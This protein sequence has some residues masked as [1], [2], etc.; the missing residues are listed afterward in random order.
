MRA[1]ATAVRTVGQTLPQDLLERLIAADPAL[2][3][4]EPTAYHLPPGESPRNAANRAWAYLKG[5]W[6]DFVAEARARPERDAQTGFTRDRWLHL[7]LRELGFG[8]V[9]TTPAGGISTAD[10]TYAVSHLWGQV[11]IHLLGWNV[12]LDRR[13][14]GVTGAAGRAPHAMVQELLNRADDYL[15]AIVS[16]GRLLRLLRD[17]TSLTGVSYV[18]FDLEAIFDQELYSDFVLLY[19]MVHQSRVETL[20][21]GAAS[22]CWL[23]RWRTSA[24]DSGVRA[25]ELLREGVQQA[26]EAL[27]TGFLRHPANHELRRR[28][29]EEQMSA[30]ELHRELLRLV[31]RLLFLFVAEDRPGT[32][33]L[34]GP[35]A[36]RTAR[37]RY[38]QHYSTAQLRRRARLIRRTSHSDE[39]QRTWVVLHCLGDDGAPALALP[40]LRGLFSR[41]PG[42]FLCAAAPLQVGSATLAGPGNQLGNNDFLSAVRALSVIRPKGQPEQV[43]DFGRLDAE[44]L[45]SIYESLLE[46][47][48]RID[49]ETRAFTLESLAGNDRK[50]SGSYY[51]PSSLIDLVLDEALDPLLDN[52]ERATDPEAALLAL[53]VCDPACGSGHF[54]VA[55]ARRIAE[56][57]AAVRSNDRDLTLDDLTEAT[58]EV[59][60]RA[61]HGVDLNPMAAELAKVSLWLESMHPGRPLAFLDHRIRVGNSLVG[62]TPALLSR[63]VP[64]AAYTALTGDD[65][66]VTGALK[67]RNKVERR[68][69]DALFSLTEFGAKDVDLAR[70]IENLDVVVP[71]RTLAELDAIEAR[72][73]RL[74]HD[75]AV[76]AAYREADTWCAAFVQPKTDP[77]LGITSATVQSAAER[78]LPA[79]LAAVV[80]EA[81]HDHNFFHWH[82]EFPHIFAAKSAEQL[83]EDDPTGWTGGFDAVIGNPPWETVQMSEKEFFAQRDTK[84]AEAPNAAERKRRI[85][86]L[87][88]RNPALHAAFHAAL[89]HRQASNLFVRASGRYPLTAHGKINTYSLFAELFRSSIDSGGRMGIITPTGLATDST[90]AAFFDDTLRSRRLA[91]FYDFENEA[92][93]F[94]G[95]H[96]QFRFATTVMTGGA[97][98]GGV[99]LAFY[100]RYVHDVS[101]RR[102]DLEPAEV[103]ALNPN[104]GTLPLC[105]ARRDADITLSIYRR[106][107]V[108]MADAPASNP[109]GLFFSQG[110]FNMA[111]DSGLF[112]T[113]SE[114]YDD[115][116]T[117]DGWAF[118]ND[119]QVWLPLYEAKILGHYDHRFS[120]Y[121]GATQAQLNKGTLPRLSD[122][123][124]DDPAQEPLA[125]YWVAEP[126]V[127]KAL[128]HRWTHD[129]LLGWRDITNASNERTFVPSVL[130][131]AAVGHVFP[132]FLPTEIGHATALEAMA[133]AFV[134]DYVSRQKLSGTHMTYEVL[135]Q[136]ACPTPEHFERPLAGV[137][138]SAYGDWVRPRVLELTYTSWRM[139]GYARD[140]MQLPE[141]ADPGPPF[142]WLPE[143]REA[144]RAELDAAM[145]HLY[146]LPRDDVEHVLD[147]FDGVRGSDERDHGEF[148]T[149]RLILQ[150]WDAMAEAARAGTA[151]RSPLDPPP[152]EGPRHP[153]RT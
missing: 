10:R 120:T 97:P 41:E 38:V 140:V 49:T 106:F 64:D 72:W 127:E 32:N 22:D 118:A 80:T 17:S 137:C 45:G 105:R 108:L 141:A 115:G 87:K 56:R 153:C 82:L 47:V 53:T 134:F 104:T 95:V 84:I 100:T 52:A 63:G 19:L 65:K 36:E 122:Q 86:G 24:R 93:I 148:R 116:Q 132:L 21:G 136:L 74:Q 12:P 128:D 142:R 18:E 51:T 40:P 112:R 138:D 42:E 7:L 114:L 3:G 149:K 73:S 37:E 92:K 13:S 103:L 88:I 4:L 1:T 44:E 89:R 121:A 111:S 135:K 146:G 39:W 9:P 66:S 31:Y 75:P 125:R 76:Q 27:G 69:G 68:G 117:F 50:T 57:L 28:L 61:V 126:E 107:P 130:P 58:R 70:Q 77:S 124:H 33:A 101:G 55:A 119:E 133:S 144:L 16:N 25:R 59:V 20:D 54:L 35:D 78:P 102:F 150:V 67:K 29:D 90:T 46:L 15:W 14:K 23:E 5:H 94:P 11:P 139:A 147:S 98:V 34:L 71:Q 91:A 2:G 131:R 26:I 43:V 85:H 143:R 6:A 48:P 123:Q 109:W 99:R 151:Y 145:F 8:R 129:W 60:V 30:S 96:N 83:A 110:L 62:A 79:E 113:A 81:A 152:G